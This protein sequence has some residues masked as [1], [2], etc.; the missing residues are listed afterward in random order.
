[1]SYEPRNL[2]W[3]DPLIATAERAY[4][5]LFLKIPELPEYSEDQKLKLRRSLYTTG[6]IWDPKNET[7]GYGFPLGKCIGYIGEPRISPI[8]GKTGKNIILI[9]RTF[10]EEALE[11]VAMSYI[12]AAIV[13]KEYFSPDSYPKPKFLSSPISRNSIG[14]IVKFDTSEDHARQSAHELVRVAHALELS[15]RHAQQSF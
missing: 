6:E 9:E 3:V 7:E 8:M 5:D 15:I 2:E 4:R 12:A 14:L 1:M 10:E 13:A 11:Q